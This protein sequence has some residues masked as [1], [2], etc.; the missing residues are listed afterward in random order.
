VKVVHVITDLGIGGAEMVLCNVLECSRRNASDITHSVLSLMKG[1]GLRNRIRAAGIEVEEFDLSRGSVPVSQAFRLANAVRRHRP[2]IIQGWMYHGILAATVARRLRSQPCP[3]IWAIHHCPG[4]LQDE[5]AS[6]RAVIRLGRPLS[7]V[8]AAI[9]YCARESA[10]QHES[11]GYRTEKTVLIPNGFDT[12]TFK[13]D[14]EAK[15]RLAGEIGVSQG[16]PIVGV[17]ARFHPQKDHHNI[18]AA[19]AILSKRMRDVHFAFVGSNVDPTNRALTEM[20]DAFG[21]QERVTLLGPR[22]DVSRIM[23]GLDVLCSGSAWGEACPIVLGEAMASG[24]PCVATEVGD[25]ALIVGDTGIVVPP[26]NPE[27]LAEGLSRLIAVGPEGR[28]QLGEAARRRIIEHFSLAEIVRQ[29]EA[30][31]RRVGRC[32]DGSR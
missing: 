23:A 31:Y 16:T 6:S 32:A 17:V 25:S 3:L 30:L 15:A 13:P 7:R 29:Y 14:P 24:V 4:T 8:P 20:I 2:D 12:E 19:A 22:Q 5:K 18:T 27:A 28:G 9:V 1:G 11:L 26:G 10:R 21:V